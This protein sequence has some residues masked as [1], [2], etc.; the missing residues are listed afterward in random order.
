MVDEIPYDEVIDETCP[1]CRR[2]VPQGTIVCP[3]CGFQIREE[4]P[5]PAPVSEPAPRASPRSRGGMNKAG[6]GGTLI[7]VS[8]ILAILTGL[9]M[10]V[11]PNVFIRMFSDIGYTLTND[12]IMVSG[13]VEII[14]GAIAVAGG[15]MAI[16]RK[17]WGLAVVGGILA[18]LASGG[19]FLGALLGL[20]GLIFVVLGRREFTR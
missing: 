3:N 12:I 5:G 11:D 6:F 16:K 10:I 13:A 14:F 19:L 17:A 8:G 18:F 2:S 15:F 4:V 9:Y 20:I 1:S 7:L